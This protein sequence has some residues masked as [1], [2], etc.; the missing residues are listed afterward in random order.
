MMFIT[1]SRRRQ[2][3]GLAL[4]ATLCVGVAMKAGGA[5]AAGGDKQ[6]AKSDIELFK[7]NWDVTKVFKDGNDIPEEFLKEIKLKF[8]GN[9]IVFSFQDIQKKATITIDA[10]KK[11]KQIDLK[12][13][14]GQDSGYGIFEFNGD[15]VKIYAA[16]VK[17]Q[18]PKDF[19]SDA[20]L[21][22][23]LKRA[24]A[25]KDAKTD[26]KGGRQP[27]A[28][29]TSLR[30]VQ[31]KS[32][33]HALQGKWIVT[34][35]IKGGEAM[36]AEFVG[37][38]K[39]GF[40]GDKL[41][42]D[43]GE[44]GTKNGSFKINDGAKPHELDMTLDG[45]TVNCIY[46]IDKDTLKLCM[47][48]KGPGGPRP[49][50]FKSDAGSPN[51]VM[52]FK[53]EKTEK[54]SRVEPAP[55]LIAF[56]PRQE[57]TAAKSDKDLIQGV[58]SVEAAVDDGLDIPDEIR[59]IVRFHVAGDKIE[60][61]I[62]DLAMK[63]TYKVD[64]TKKPKTV[65]INLDSGETMIGIYEMTPD[66]VKFCIAPK[67]DGT[68]PPTEFKSAAGSGHKL[69]M[70]KRAKEEKK[71]APNQPR[72][73]HEVEV[74]FDADQGADKDQAL[75][76]GTWQI[77]AFTEGGEKKNDDQNAQIK[78]IV[79]GNSISL[80]FEGKGETKHGT[81]KLDSSKKPKQID[82]IPENG[83]DMKI[84]GIYE[85]TADTF[86]LCATMGGPRPTEYK[87]EAGSNTVLAEMKRVVAKKLEVQVPPAKL[88]DLDRITGE[89]KL[90]KAHGDGE[91]A[92][93]DYVG[94]VRLVF[95]ADGT[96]NVKGL[97][98]DD[99]G[100]F[101]IDAEAK[102]K[103][104]TWFNA[105]T[106]RT[107]AGIYKI[108]GDKLVLCFAQAPSADN[109][110]TE[111]TSA[112]GTGQI[113]FILEQL[114][115]GQQM[116][117]AKTDAIEGAGRRRSSSNLSRI[118]S[119][120]H[121]HH[122]QYGSFPA[123]A[124][125]SKDDKTPLLSWRVA[126]LPY[127]GEVELYKQFRLDEPWDSDHNKKLI[128]KM[129]KI[130]DPIHLGSTQEGLTHYQVF[131]GKDSVFDGPK[132]AKMPVDFKDG[133]SNTILV[134]EAKGSVIW[135]KPDDLV[136]PNKGDKMPEL[137]G[138]FSAGMNL[139]FCDGSVQFVRRDIDAVT[140]RAIITPSGGEAFD[141]KALQQPATAMKK[142]AK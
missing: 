77:T 39:M 106:L 96:V 5:R 56:R 58:W 16:E 110:P 64:E 103:Q 25:D 80:Q 86:K 18:R 95:E 68:K 92:P 41:I 19:K 72:R 76:Q 35:G 2:A 12:F 120:M 136:L 124:I 23:V 105:V 7:G 49:T 70:L 88:S 50:E 20:P 123:H 37:K 82:I 69:V 85:V 114:Q 134:V 131:T 130:Y 54:K 27:N 21:V 67:E 108:D 109:R 91:D 99:K 125:Y 1:P 22:I 101:K 137:G 60:I 89:W 119:A 66:K 40:D 71:L 52:L 139:L 34:G 142:D 102:P 30:T 104:V 75:F 79:K 132:K 117:K 100:T 4:F 81:Y 140:L 51:T 127:I 29:T 97:P 61:K 6:D 36:P 10:T 31:G 128:A 107:T 90:L 129:P 43:A 116:A 93:P 13:E 57:K 111:F 65:E 14:D 112:K 121:L 78:V 32:T 63:G 55:S 73:G 11:P 59:D 98:N 141:R 115:T 94:P 113:I 24:P 87:S 122:D 42:V 8:T 17:E 26:K 62:G 45:E 53:R 126:I 135:T 48:A 38:F 138:M 9:T 83:G 118:G 84:E 47:N 74:G 46:E 44:K 28:V 133:T 33:K 3:V 15:T